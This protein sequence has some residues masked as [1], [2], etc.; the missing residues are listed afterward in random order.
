MTEPIVGCLQAI[1]SRREVDVQGRWR[2]T[3]LT[4]KFRLTKSQKSL[5][6]LQI[7]ALKSSTVGSPM[8]AVTVALIHLNQISA[9]KPNIKTGLI[10]S[11]LDVLASGQQLLDRK[12]QKNAKIEEKKEM[13]SSKQKSKKI[14]FDPVAACF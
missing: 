3:A 5:K 8:V 14:R 1:F 6:E 9:L 11:K 2:S 10:Q 13:K 4:S 7:L 12:A